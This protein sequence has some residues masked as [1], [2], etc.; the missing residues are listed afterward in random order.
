MTVIWKRGGLDIPKKPDI[1]N[2]ESTYDVTV[3]KTRSMGRPVSK[4][5][6]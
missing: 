3:Q 2:D 4:N 6:W 1:I 5:H